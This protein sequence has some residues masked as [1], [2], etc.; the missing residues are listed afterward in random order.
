[1]SKR[2]A[3]MT[4]YKP[5][6]SGALLPPPPAASQMEPRSLS[7]PL[8]EGESSSP[9]VTASHQKPTSE[10]AQQR[11][12]LGRCQ[13]DSL[14]CVDTIVPSNVQQQQPPLQQAS[15]PSDQHSARK[16]APADQSEEEDDDQ[17]GTFVIAQS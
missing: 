15:S 8:H 7:G 13:Q 16:Q 2:L 10:T 12:L 3:A 17:F 5:Y 6:H 11:G 9:E 1:M 14:A 4:T